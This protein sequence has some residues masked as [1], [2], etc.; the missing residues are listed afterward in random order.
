VDQQAYRHL[1]KSIFA[2]FNIGIELAYSGV[3]W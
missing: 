3:G 2:D 1:A